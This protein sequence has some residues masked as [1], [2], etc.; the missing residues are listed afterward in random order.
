MVIRMVAR[1]KLESTE[2]TVIYPR[3]ESHEQRIA[4][5]AGIVQLVSSALER[6]D[7]RRVENTPMFMKSENG[8]IGYALVGSEIFICEGD[9]EREVGDVLKAILKR[10]NAGDDELYSGVDHEIRRKGK[11]IGDLW[12]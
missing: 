1:F 11:E 5:L 8:V 9:G 2:S 12:Q 6:S 4:L 10:P 7:N 3:D